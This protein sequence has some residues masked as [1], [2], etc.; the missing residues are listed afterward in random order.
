MAIKD[1]RDALTALEDLAAHARTELI[2]DIDVSRAVL[3]R[4]RNDHQESP[5]RQRRHPTGKPL[6]ILSPTVQ[7]QQQRRRLR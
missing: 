6:A 2:P 5:L 7:G 1:Q 4:L 3:R